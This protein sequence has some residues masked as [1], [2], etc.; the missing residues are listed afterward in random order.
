MR[1]RTMS[2]FP[3]LLREK[4]E[5]MGESCKAILDGMDSIDK[6][7]S[8]LNEAQD[9]K[10]K[11]SDEIFSICEELIP[12]VA[13]YLV[14][15]KDQQEKDTLD[16]LSDVI[17][18]IMV[19]IESES[20][21]EKVSQLSELD[22]IYNAAHENEWIKKIKEILNQKNIKSSLHNIYLELAVMD[23]LSEDVIASDVVTDF[24]EKLTKDSPVEYTLLCDASAESIYNFLATLARY[25]Q[26]N[27]DNLEKLG[28]YFDARNVAGENMDLDVISAELKQRLKFA[29][30]DA[31]ADFISNSK[32]DLTPRQVLRKS[33][34][35]SERHAVGAVA[36]MN[37]ALSKL[38]ALTS[39]VN[40][41]VEVLKSESAS[42]KQLAEKSSP[43][44]PTK[45]A[46]ENDLGEQVV[47]YHREN[48]QLR[49]ALA[50]TADEFAKQI[51]ALQVGANNP[52]AMPNSRSTDIPAATWKKGNQGPAFWAR[53]SQSPFSAVPSA[54]TH[55]EPEFKVYEDHP[56]GDRSKA[57]VETAQPS[58][59]GLRRRPVIELG[60][61]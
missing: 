34:A 8:K 41:H 18:R 4:M 43:L 48:K 36:K 3:Q 45:G 31:M 32:L 39:L 6:L 17:T 15:S 5:K 44:V 61:T 19:R 54:A 14:D 47:N 12:K 58:N 13:K 50:R 7:F 16:Q 55:P 59:S 37:E 42:F 9:G 11:I 27:D 40:N 56:T 2:Q 53:H 33:L 46:K 51:K 30:S 22:E 26:L 25:G 38:E 1:L 52:S 24:Y 21:L 49:E 20:S 28:R 60:L 57:A 29:K 10:N 35:A 23:V